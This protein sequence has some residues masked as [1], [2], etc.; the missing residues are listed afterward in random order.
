MELRG[1][2]GRW[3]RAQVA[4]LGGRAAIAAFT[5]VMDHRLRER[6]LRDSE[7]LN[8]AIVAGL[9]E[10]VLV[11]DTDLRV[12]LA[13]EAAAR[14]IGVSVEEMVG[15]PLSAIPTVVLDETG[16]PIDDEQMPIVRAMRGETVRGA[17]VRALRRDGALLWVEV[18][19]GPLIE[20]DRVYGVVATFEDV[21]ARIEQD[22]RT[23][24]EADT[25]AL[26]GLAN[27][28]ALGPALAR[29]AG[30]GRSVALL[31]LDLDGFKAVND[32]FGHA[33]GDEALRE[34]ARRLRRC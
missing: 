14:H 13:N 4:P 29:A 23:R 30:R 27:R 18:N 15:A 10:G 5:G 9:Q 31:M 19:A 20:D 24:H 28:R 1:G 25:D 12:V 22:R 3:W 16:R 34:V 32:V 2:D 33:A 26:T 6:S 7:R 8:R 17:L 21:T 11:V